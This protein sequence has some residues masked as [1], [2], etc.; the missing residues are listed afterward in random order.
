MQMYMGRR[1]RQRRTRAPARPGGGK[2]WGEHTALQVTDHARAAL[3]PEAE[4]AGHRRQAKKAGGVSCGAAQ[5][6][7]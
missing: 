3:P 4:S 7:H 5:T 1:R 6:A 2:G